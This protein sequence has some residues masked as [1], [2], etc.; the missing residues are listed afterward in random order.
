MGSVDGGATACGPTESPPARRVT[1]PAYAPAVK[2]TCWP[3]EA[4]DRPVKYSKLVPLLEFD[5]MVAPKLKQFGTSI[6]H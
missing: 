3:G 1:S 4:Q 6:R 2:K 5:L